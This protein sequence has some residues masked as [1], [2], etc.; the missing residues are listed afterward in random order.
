MTRK[1]YAFL[2]SVSRK[3]RHRLNDISLFQKLL[4]IVLNNVFLI[5]ILLV[6]GL[7][8]CSSAYNRLLYKTTAGNL[9]YS[10]YTISESL[11]SIEAVSSSIIAAPEIQSAL[12]DVA[13]SNDMPAWTNANRIIN[14]SLQTYHASVKN[15]GAS[16]LM[17]QN[18][19]FSNSTYT[20]W[21]KKL[22][23][24]TF[25]TAVEAA[26]ERNGAVTWTPADPGSNSL[27]M[28]RKI[29]K[30]NNLELS[31][32]GT[33]VIYVDLNQI[34]E[35]ANAATNQYSDS[36]YILCSGNQMI[37][38][39]DIFTDE[40]VHEIIS[41]SRDKYQTITLDS[42]TYFTVHNRIP[43]YNMEYYSLVP[44]HLIRS[45]LKNF[46]ILIQKMERFSQDEA[47]LLSTKYDSDYAYRK[48]EIGRLHQ[49][50]ERMTKRIQNLVNTNY[51]N[52]LLTREAQIKALESQINP[53]F[54]YNTLE[55]INWR[56]KAVNNQEI[57]LMT[58]SLGSLLR[59]TLSNKKSLVTLSYELSL[60]N[61]YITIQQ[62]RF[63]ERLEFESQIPENLKNA[64]LPP[65]TLQPLVENAIHY[66]LEEIM[67]TCYITIQAEELPQDP[68]GR[69]ASLKILVKNSGS[70]FEDNLLELLDTQQ[71][72][73][74]RSGIGL[75][76]INKRIKL[77]F[78]DAYGLSLYNEGEFAVAAITIPYRTEE[79]VSC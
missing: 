74:N 33:L 73:P 59:A 41:S 22:S 24:K 13:E 20:V 65:L 3:I 64:L 72:T 70:A 50:F 58:E 23:E 67:E 31:H 2:H 9:T 44:Y 71:K 52:E 47:A 26:D 36:Q 10:S 79:S 55:S 21:K 61:S 57:S 60:I 45:I 35:K 15:N 49:G 51:V 17:I 38:V 32:L 62:I 5:V 12:T 53:H 11:K 29:R 1:F 77:L 43:G 56:A 39:P 37:Y 34:I 30:V 68:S 63:E 6:L 78:G 14:N 48:D 69:E 25:E 4:F 8:I 7:F 66:A 27:L 18:E 40:E 28:S 19:H 42:H 54:L 16:F 75:L 46:N 76:N